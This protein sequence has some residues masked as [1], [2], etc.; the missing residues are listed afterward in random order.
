VIVSPP[1]NGQLTRRALLG[2]AAAAAG[3]VSLGRPAGGLAS[4]LDL[5]PG[6]FSRWVG[7]LRGNS[8]VLAAP[9]RFAMVG[10]E[11]TGPAGARIELR[12]RASGREWGRWA[13][14]SVLGHG[15]DR[16]QG[17]PGAPGATG[18]PATASAPG[19][20]RT[21]P[22]REPLF[23]E[24]IWT[25]SADSIQ[26]RSP[27]PVH[28]LRL[29][30][31]SPS[32]PR[33][34][35]ASAAVPLAV[36]VLDAGPGQPPIISRDA[37]AQAQAPPRFPAAYGSVRLAF[38]HHTETPNGYS[39]G[40]VPAMLLSIYHFHRFVRGWNDI[41]YNF[42]IDAFGRI[43]EARA[44][45]ID[46]AVIGAQAGGYNLVSTGVAVLGSFTDVVPAPAAIDALERLLAWKLSLHGVPTV[47][48]VTVEVD[49]A[50]AFF[51]P[52]APGAHVSLPRVAG[53]R[54]GDSTSCPGNAFYA[55]LPSIRPRVAAL[56]GTPA[57]VTLAAK[58]TVV[59]PNTRLIVSGRLMQLGGPPIAGAPIEV[60][61][62]MPGG[63]STV[64][65]ATTAADGTWSNVLE[66]ASN[67]LVR[68]LHR[69]APATLSNVAFVGL[70]PAV[71]LIV[72]SVS[73][74]H[75]SGTMIPSKRMVAIDLYALV[76]GRR[77]LVASKRVA[78]TR[79]RFAARLRTRRH[80]PA[81][82]VARTTADARTV[83][84]ASP[85]VNVTL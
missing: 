23:G 15:P 43:W 35:I 42:A 28:G 20:P 67:L 4:A 47:G 82:L 80:G 9:R 53:H 60:Q 27:G 1:A 16:A 3:A 37:W 17:A 29:H 46:E 70:Q 40:D 76:N 50:D 19:S 48:R 58:P 22:D 8:A 81:L 5:R 6:V 55:R 7:S 2:S 36:P 49:P 73:P 45:G 52:F 31:V 51:T 10:V 56:A 24:A 83:A 26:L 41:G 65:T 32:A 69:P 62:V 34:G 38:V 79:G 72:D 30:F 11:W 84:G 68:A 63:A 85:P 21:A 12:T 33:A 74:L 18:A 64:A 71:T 75:V 78:V 25:G 54:D 57:T 59:A 61:Q 66:P 44:G 77:R 39:R 13:L 14:A